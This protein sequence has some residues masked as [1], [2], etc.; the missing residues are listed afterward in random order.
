MTRGAIGA[1]QHLPRCTGLSVRGEVLQPAPNTSPS[2]DSM[3]ANRAM[4]DSIGTNRNGSVA[5][6]C[7]SIFAN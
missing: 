3:A 1:I 7:E 4:R 2:A 6:E 5:L